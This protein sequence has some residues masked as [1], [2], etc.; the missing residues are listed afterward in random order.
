MKVRYLVFLWFNLQCHSELFSMF[1][2]TSMI[3]IEH[4]HLN[5]FSTHLRFNKARMKCQCVYIKVGKILLLNCAFWPLF[6]VNIQIGMSHVCDDAN[7]WVRWCLRNILTY[8]IRIISY[9]FTKR[10]NKHLSCAERQFSVCR[11]ERFRHA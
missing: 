8:C 10:R 3:Y 4:L 7:I 2:Y 11:F 9:S 1:F 6:V 5:H